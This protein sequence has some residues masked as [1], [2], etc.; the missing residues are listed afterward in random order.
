[1]KTAPGPGLKP[2]QFEIAYNQDNTP[3]PVILFNDGSIW[4]QC[5][6]NWHCVWPAFEPVQ[7]VAR[8]ADDIQRIA[9]LE[10]QVKGLRECTQDQAVEIGLLTD[11]RDEALSQSKRNNSDANKWCKTSCLAKA[12]VRKLE[13]QIKAWKEAASV[14]LV[15]D[16]DD[17]PILCRTPAELVERLKLLYNWASSAEERAKAK[18]ERMCPMRF[19]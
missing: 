1:M 19:N 10:A 7:F 9:E 13:A 3:Y 6:E 8:R 18:N 5:V 2:V 12:E 15:N 16:G 4:R 11:Q 14:D 17:D